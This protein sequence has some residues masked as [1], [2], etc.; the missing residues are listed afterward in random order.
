MNVIIGG[1]CGEVLKNRRKKKHRKMIEIGRDKE[2]STAKRP[3]IDPLSRTGVGRELG[4]SNRGQ[5]GSLILSRQGNR[6]NNS[7]DSTLYI[8]ICCG[9]V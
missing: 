9:Y 4:V 7:V 5:R 2:D 6:I 3:R 1:R 8:K